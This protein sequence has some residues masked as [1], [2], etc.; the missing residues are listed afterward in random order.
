[1][2]IKSTDWIKDVKA[3][4]EDCEW[5]LSNFQ[6]LWFVGKQL[7]DENTLQNCSI[8]DGSIV[9]I[10]FRLPDE[11]EIVVKTFTGKCIT[12]NVKPTDQIK[13]VKAKNT[14]HSSWLGS[15]HALQDTV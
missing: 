10:V 11:M 5:I 7:K 14:L 6:R 1:L 13:D 2:E 8:Q 4:I 9:H 3:K 15:S 12:L